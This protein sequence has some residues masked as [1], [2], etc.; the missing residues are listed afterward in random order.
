MTAS[1]SPLH[2]CTTLRTLLGTAMLAACTLTVVGTALRPASADD[3][4]TVTLTAA[5]RDHLL[6]GM[7]SY[8]TSLADVT[9]ALSKYDPG[10]V[11]RAARRSGAKMLGDIPPLVAF[12]LPPEFTAMSL[13]THEQFDQLA[14][15]AQARVGRTELLSDLAAIMV[16]CN[17]CHAAYQ[18]VV[19]P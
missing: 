1:R 17:G 2:H 11:A 3:R 16:N 7:R 8:L 4:F 13:A 10:A 5:E 9:E 12:K 19:A 6:A 18:L 15:R 14:R